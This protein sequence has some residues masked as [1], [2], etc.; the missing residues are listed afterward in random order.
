VSKVTFILEEKANFPVT[1][2]CDVLRVSTS[3]FYGWTT[4]P[5]CARALEDRQLASDIQLAHNTGRGNYGTRR[6]HKVVAKRGWSVSAKRVAR[7]RREEGLTVKRR[8]RF[9]ATTDS[10]HTD[11]V[12]PN[13]LDRAFSVATPNRAWVTD[14]TYVWTLQGWLYLSVII[15]LCSRRVVGWATSEFNDRA[16]ALDAL[17]R[18]FSARRPAAQWVHHSDR[19]SVYASEDYR[20]ALRKLRGTVSMSRKGNCWDNA[21]AE[22]FFASIK[23]ECLD[24]APLYSRA[25]AAALIADYIDNFYNTC[26]LHST[27]GYVSPVEYELKLQPSKTPA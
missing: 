22:S 4:R 9:K 16:L 6:I 2:M 1:V 24:H 7:I 15:D 26:I 14:V 11:P 8:H 25:Q 18:A 5:K 19:G 10:K 12:A 23:G 27:I 17:T 20:K 21:V 3:G 13:A